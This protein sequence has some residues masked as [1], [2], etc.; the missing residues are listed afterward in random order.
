[1]LMRGEIPYQGKRLSRNASSKRH[2]VAKKARMDCDLIHINVTHRSSRGDSNT[3]SSPISMAKSSSSVPCIDSHRSRNTGSAILHASNVDFQRVV[4]NP[5]VNFTS[6][7][8]MHRSRKS[9][10]ASRCFEHQ[11][12]LTSCYSRLT[13]TASFLL[14]PSAGDM[15]TR[16][17]R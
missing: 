9:S 1:M 5:E 13:L 17:I 8:S 12:L 11:R 14:M 15:C 2:I 6:Q 4:S 3:L 7:R 16:S 10:C